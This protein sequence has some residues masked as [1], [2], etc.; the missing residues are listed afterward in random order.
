MNHQNFMMFIEGVLKIN[1]QGVADIK[2]QLPS[3]YINNVGEKE[4]PHLHFRL[5][6][7]NK[8]S[9]VYTLPI[10]FQKINL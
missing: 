5:C 8:M 9:P 3:G 10:H 2:L 7:D 4:S 6:S 1:R